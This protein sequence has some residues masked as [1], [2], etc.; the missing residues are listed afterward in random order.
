MSLYRTASQSVAGKVKANYVTWAAMT[1]VSMALMLVKERVISVER[2][3]L[4]SLPAQ[5]RKVRQGN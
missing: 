5:S 1:V 4:L 2:V 3:S